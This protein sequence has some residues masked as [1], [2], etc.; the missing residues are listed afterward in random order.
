V[1]VSRTCFL[2][3]FLW[4]WGGFFSSFSLSVALSFS[5]N[6]AISFT[7][8]FSVTVQHPNPFLLPLSVQ[9]TSTLFKPLP[10]SFLHSAFPFSFG[11]P[12]SCPF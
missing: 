9:L 6:L 11:F 10:L 4:G 1:A 7:F 5:F 3:V 12:F 8:P 2:K